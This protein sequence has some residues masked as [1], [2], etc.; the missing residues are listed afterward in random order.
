MHLFILF[1]L[2]EGRINNYNASMLSDLCCVSSVLIS[3]VVFGR[4]KNLL[5]LCPIHMLLEWIILRKQVCKIYRRKFIQIVIASYLFWTMQGRDEKTSSGH[6]ISILFNK[7]DTRL[8]WEIPNCILLLVWNCLS[9]LPCNNNYIFIY[10]LPWKIIMHF[11]QEIIV[12]FL[13]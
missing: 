12:P 3:S 10:F 11:F 7:K 9:G 5:L 2:Q 6:L 13:H 4:A 8:T 1:Y